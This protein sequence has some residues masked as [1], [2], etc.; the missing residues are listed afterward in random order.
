MLQQS[1]CLTR[2]GSIYMTFAMNRQRVPFRR[3]TTRS[4]ASPLTKRP[5]LTICALL[6]LLI[7]LCAATDF[8]YDA[9]DCVRNCPF[10]VGFV[11]QFE[12]KHEL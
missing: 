11:L 6:S 4:A 1:E 10:Q 9:E 5:A 3:S 12:D 2:F 8:H 7:H